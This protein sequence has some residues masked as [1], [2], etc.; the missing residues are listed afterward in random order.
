MV[1]GLALTIGLNF[2]DPKHYAGW[3]GQLTAC[4]YDAEDMTDIAKIKGF[5]VQKFLTKTATCENVEN[6]IS[7]A[8]KKLENGDIFLLSYS[9]HGGQLPDKNSDELDR[10]DETWC[11]YDRQFVDDE[12]NNCLAQFT[13]GVRVLVF[14]DSCHSGTVTRAIAANKNIDQFNSNIDIQ[15]RK[16]RFAPKNVIART[17]KQNKSHY[18]K[19]LANRNL[20]ESDD[21]VKASVFLY[22][23]AKIIN[24]RKMGNLMDSL[25][26]IY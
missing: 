15:D 5:E 7:K 2:V 6:G 25:H 22:L 18:D 9:G 12:L 24:S 23:V 1:K 14:S 16:Y 10:T 26:L 17:Y 13:K 11:L 4:E 20:K 19:V 21:K 3:D 8:S